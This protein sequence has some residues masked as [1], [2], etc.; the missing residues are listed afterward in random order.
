VVPISKV[1]AM[2]RAGRAGRTSAGQCY[3]LYTKDCYDRML[4]ETVPEIQRTNLSNTV[5]YSSYA[6]LLLYSY[7]TPTVLLLHSYCTPTVLLLHS[8]CTP[9]ALLL[10]SYCT[11]TVLIL[12]CADAGK[13]LYLKCLG[14]NDVLSFDFMDKVSSLRV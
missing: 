6:V 5:L 3:R 9:T 4:E 13:V 12:H 7:C 1:S 8:Y 14:V 2:Q 10:H 11:P